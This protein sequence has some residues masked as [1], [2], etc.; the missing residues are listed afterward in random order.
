MNFNTL[1]FE[2]VVRAYQKWLQAS[3][4][5]YYEEVFDGV[6]MT[7]EM[8]T[9]LGFYYKEHLDKLPFLSE[10]GFSGNTLGVG[11]DK[12][13]LLQEANNPVVLFDK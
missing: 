2:V 4:N 13:R 11:V 3:Y 7:D 12:E 9:G 10:I 6:D 1:P 8:W 5:Y